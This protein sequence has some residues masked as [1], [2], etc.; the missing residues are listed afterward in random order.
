ML[1]HLI[2]SAIPPTRCFALKRALLRWAGAQVGANARIVSTARFYLTGRLSIG[3]DTWVGHDVLVVGGDAAVVIG[4]KVDI[5]PR[6]S[7]VTGSHKLFTIEGRAAGIGY[8]SPITIEDGAWLG[9][10]S[11]ILG[12]VTVGQCSVVAAGALVNRN[13]KQGIVCG[14]VPARDLTNLMSKVDA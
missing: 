7:L 5:G 1:M 4:C 12:G 3:N 2:M 6:V 14:G 10:A 13:V 8:S 11:T 9:A